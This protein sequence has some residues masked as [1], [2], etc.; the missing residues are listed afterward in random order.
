MSVFCSNSLI[1]APECCKCIKFKE[2]RF[3]NVSKLAPSALASCTFA[4]SFFLLHLLQSIFHV[5]KILLKTPYKAWPIVVKRQKKD[6]LHCNLSANTLPR[7]FAGC[8]F[9]VDEEGCINSC[10]FESPT[11][12]S[13][14][15]ATSSPSLPSKP[16][17]ISISWGYGLRG[18]P[19]WT[20]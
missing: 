4:T 15:I 16:D 17:R 3:Q 19:T 20:Q 14:S 2:P 12:C 7:A 6:T 18:S 5:L 1:S 9:E 10:R 13:V 8:E 11:G